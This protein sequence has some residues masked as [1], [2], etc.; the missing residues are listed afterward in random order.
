MF[1]LSRPSAVVVC[2]AIIVPANLA[3]PAPAHANLKKRILQMTACAAVVPAGFKLGEKLAAFDA[4]KRQLDSVESER[5]RRA[6]QLGMAAALCGTSALLTGSVY[7]KLSERDRKAREREMQAALLDA[8]TSTRSYVL[9]D[10][11]YEGKITAEAIVDEGKR[12]C[13]VTVDVLSKDGE[14]ARTRHCRKKPDGDYE[15]DI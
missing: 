9:P 6:Y 14:P 15:L 3:T 4:R 1:G 10:S 5:N 7:N 13:R 2:L 8:N 12:E 11:G